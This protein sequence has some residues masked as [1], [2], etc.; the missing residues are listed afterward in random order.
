MVRDGNILREC[1]YHFR[2]EIHFEDF[3]HRYVPQWNVREDSN[4]SVPA[5]MSV[6]TQS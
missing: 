4:L 2:E 3:R 5:V 6:Q 1:T